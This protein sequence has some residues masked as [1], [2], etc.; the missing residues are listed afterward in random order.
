VDRVKAPFTD[1]QVDAIN[2]WQNTSTVHPLTCGSGNR[3]DEKH[4]DGE[5]ILVASKD[6]L[7]CPYCDY[8][9]DWVPDGVAFPGEIFVV[10]EKFNNYIQMGLKEVSPKGVSTTPKFCGWCG[11][12][13]EPG[14]FDA[15]CSANAGEI[16]FHRNCML[17]QA[18]GSVGHQQGQC[19]CYVDG[20]TLGDP[21]DMTI[22]QAADAAV[23][24]WNWRNHGALKRN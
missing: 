16:S 22:R 19:S 17:R 6:G 18:I 13:I 15:R 8:K 12:P 9:Q 11:E 1:E 20:S 24:F 21:E 2:Q 14:E 5:G 4:L 10:D 7:V 23:E 3:K